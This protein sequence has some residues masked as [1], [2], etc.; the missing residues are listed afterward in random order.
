MGRVWKEAYFTS[1][2][3]TDDFSRKVGGGNQLPL[4]TSQLQT[5][6]F[7]SKGHLKNLDIFLALAATVLYMLSTM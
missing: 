4:P 6:L 3:F 5:V 2:S 1:F 7:A